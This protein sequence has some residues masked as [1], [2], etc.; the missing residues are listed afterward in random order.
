[1]KKLIRYFIA[2]VAALGMT[3]T[4]CQDDAPYVFNPSEQIGYLFE[5]WDDVF[6]SYWNAM[7]YNYAFWDIETT[8][9][10]KVYTEYK[11][12][13]EELKF[14]VSEDSIKA[15]ELF[16]EIASSLKDHHYGLWL[17]KADGSDYVEIRP[18]FLEVAKR[19][20]NHAWL[21]ASQMFVNISRL[22]DSGRVTNLVG[23]CS[24]DLDTQPF[25]FYTCLID[26]SIVYLRLNAF[27]L[28]N[29]LQDEQVQAALVNYYQLIDETPSLKG[30]IID[31]RSNGGGSI[32]DEHWIL[33]PLL[34][35]PHYFADSRTKLGMGR[36]DYTPWTPLILEPSDKT[37]ERVTR[38][39]S[40]LPIVSIIDLN[41]V[42]MAEITAMAIQ[43]LPNGTVIGERSFG[44]HGPL[45]GNNHEFYTGE[46]ENSKY[47]MKTSTSMTRRLDGKCY[48]GIGVIPDIEVFYNEDEFSRGI[49]KQLNRAIEFIEKGK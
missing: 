15:K 3:M 28:I 46:V 23:N 12:Q 24:D 37:K 34:R 41:S 29:N 19:D 13:F 20:Y 45:N 11:P 21:S 1:M 47:Y 25:V 49:D 17:K 35:A 48:E 22:A 14:G 2:A 18:G 10:D 27:S 7:N 4:S 40:N 44:G 8:D 5:D 33:T 26:N 16:Y 32:D 43:E 9:W 30:I 42:S 6:E 31:T 39:V 38:D 36:L